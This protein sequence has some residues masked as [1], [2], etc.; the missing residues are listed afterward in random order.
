MHHLTC[1]HLTTHL[2]LNDEKYLVIKLFI[3]CCVFTVEFLYGYGS[4]TEKSLV[5]GSTPTT[6]NLFGVI[7]VVRRFIYLCV[8]ELC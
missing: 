1:F 5:D 2:T 8:G 7:K 6:A 3:S 4:M